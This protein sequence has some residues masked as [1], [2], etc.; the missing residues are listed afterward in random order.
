M[1]NNLAFKTN[2]SNEDLP[3]ITVMGTDMSVA[4]GKTILDAVHYE[5]FGFKA[6]Q[7]TTVTL[8]N[9]EETIMCLEALLDYEEGRTS[10]TYFYLD[11][12]DPPFYEVIDWIANNT[13]AII[14]YTDGRF[15]RC[16]IRGFNE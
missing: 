3:I 11:S 8:T 12:Y 14:D 2:R 10:Q 9:S 7:I 6:C 5:C 1:Y 16:V 13:D 4:Y 15:F